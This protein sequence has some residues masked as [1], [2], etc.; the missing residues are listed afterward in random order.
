MGRS[1]EK[2]HYDALFGDDWRKGEIGDFGG[3]EYHD[4]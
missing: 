4:Y 3:L 2:V 1:V